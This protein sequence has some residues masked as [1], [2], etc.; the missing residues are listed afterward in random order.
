MAWFF[1]IRHPIITV[2]RE[3]L[4]RC[5]VLVL[6]DDQTCAI[7]EVVLY[8]PKTVLRVILLIVWAMTRDLMALS[9][10]KTRDS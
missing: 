9:Q 1:R 6:R 4:R 7:Q 3:T 5:L 10:E 2:L 8:G